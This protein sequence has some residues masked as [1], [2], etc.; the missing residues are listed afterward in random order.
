VHALFQDALG[1]HRPFFLNE[2]MAER[3]EERARGRPGLARGE[4]RRLLEALRADEWL[5]LE[6]LV[7]GFGQLEGP[8]ALLAYLESRAG[9]ELIEAQRPGALPRWL[10]RCAKGEPWESARRAETGWDTQ[11]LDAALQAH[12]RSRFPVLPEDREADQLSS[13]AQ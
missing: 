12:V 1:A 8:S 9:V 13:G 3:E 6:T 7:A 4:W 2:G 5:P 11:G 10:A